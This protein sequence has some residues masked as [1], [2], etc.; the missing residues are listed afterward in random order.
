MNDIQRLKQLYPSLTVWEPF[1]TYHHHDLSWFFTED[2]TIIGI[3]QQELSERER[4]MLNI[5][6]TPCNPESGVASDRAQAWRKLISASDGRGDVWWEDQ[7][8]AYRFIFFSLTELTLDVTGFYEAIQSLFPKEMP[9]LWETPHLGVI[10]EELDRTEDDPIS[11]ENM[12]DVLMSDFYI[13]LHVHIGEFHFDLA[14]AAHA[15]SI[16]QHG[17]EMSTRYLRKHVTTFID[18]L[19]YFYLDQLPEETRT[20][21]IKTVLGPV[22]DDT[23]LLQTIKAFIQCNFNTTLAA[24]ELYMHRNSLQYRIDKFIEKTGIDVRQFDEA[25]TA[26]LAIL[27]IEHH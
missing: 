2:H 18:V 26:Y 25:L 19:P 17:Y 8:A 5:F 11:F 16:T 1:H 14:E 9:I 22:S 4:E 6:L 10:I 3:N 13:K 7:P 20:Y 27:Q 12:I 21:I 24:K 15:F 23:E